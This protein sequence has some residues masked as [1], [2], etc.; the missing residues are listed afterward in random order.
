MNRQE[1]DSDA[2]LRTQRAVR[3][4]WTGFFINALLSIAKIL[5]GFFGNSAAMIAD[6]IHSVSDFVTDIIVLVFVKISGK[7]SDESHCYGMASLRLLR[8]FL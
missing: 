5:A 8:P 7:G 6:G 3:V 2:A 4:M 1:L